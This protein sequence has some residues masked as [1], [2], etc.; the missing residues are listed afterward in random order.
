MTAEVD[1]QVDSNYKV[2]GTMRYCVVPLWG[3]HHGEDQV[4]AALV[5]GFDGRVPRMPEPAVMRA[6]AMHLV[7]KR[8]A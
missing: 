3:H 6:I 7:D 1:S 5:L 8:P 2:V 4:V